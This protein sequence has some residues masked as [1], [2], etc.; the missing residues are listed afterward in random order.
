[1]RH[2]LGYYVRGLSVQLLPILLIMKNPVKKRTFTLA[3]CSVIAAL[4]VVLMML[5]SLIPV[6][7]YAL[8]MFSGALLVAVVV[9][10]NC[11]WAFGVY[12][13]ASV[14]SVFLAGDKEAVVL[15]IALFG[16]YPIVKNIFER[17][18]KSKP[19]VIV[20]KLALFNLA[21]VAA[22]LFTSF[23]LKVSA[24]EYTVFG[25][26]VPYIFLILGNIIFL[27]YD[28][29]LTIFVIFYVK[30]ISPKL[31]KNGKM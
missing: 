26:Y 4:A 2:L 18:I 11:K 24:E 30:V 6:G 10:F 31:F 20:L 25:F 5:T 22:F 16:Y 13:V 17:K 7:T 3:Y 15:F 23:L 1:M 14:L 29:A 12:L 9:E 27:F 8:P 19:L 21:A 28:R